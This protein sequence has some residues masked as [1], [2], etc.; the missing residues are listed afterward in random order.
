MTLGTSAIVPDGK[1]WKPVKWL[2]GQ[3][4]SLS[5]FKA[6]ALH[7]GVLFICCMVCHGEVYRLRPPAR[8]LTGYYLMIAAGGAGGGFFVAAI[9]PLVFK[10]Y[11]ELQIGLFAAGL[12]AALALVCDAK[13][14]L[15]GFRPAWAWVLITLALTG[16][17]V[18]FY[19]DTMLAKS[20]ALAMNRNF[21]GVLKV[22]EWNAGDPHWHKLTLQHGTTTHGLQYQDEERRNKPT[23]YYVPSSG[24]GLAMQHYPREPRR[25]GVVG[26]GTG[27]MAAWGQA[28]DHFRF[29]EINR[30]VTNFARS[31]FTYL[32]DCAAEV[33]VVM[34]DARLSLEREASQQFDLLVLDAFSSDAI[35]VHLLTREAFEIYLRHLRTNGVLVVH[36]SNKYLDLQPVVRRA[37]E[38]FGLGLALISNSE[39]QSGEDGEESSYDFYHSDWVLLTRNRAFL[40]LPA[41]ANAQTALSTNAP[42]IKL[43]TDDRSDL[44]SILEL[45]DEGWLAWLRRKVR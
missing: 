39:E 12:L 36:I 24:V 14:P 44:F 26:L 43:W 41:I 31:R 38:H 45:E 40:K 17:G 30:A 42:A 29:Y 9:A 4:E 18:G 6:I 35:P 25:V 1:W 19:K 20:G 8:Q 2:S 5:L 13:S 23:S 10:G 21:Y 22:E 3:A 37:A 11:F 16:L 33:E 27:S 34:G 28:G 15:R 32:A 7:L